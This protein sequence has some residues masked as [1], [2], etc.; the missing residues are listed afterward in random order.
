MY[1]CRISSPAI[2]AIGTDEVALRLDQPVNGRLSG[3]RLSHLSTTPRVLG[4]PHASF[5]SSIQH[6]SDKGDK[7]VKLNT[8]TYMMGPLSI[9]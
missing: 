3:P 2:V 6:I 8:H 5:L 7:K 9:S 4:V 1:V